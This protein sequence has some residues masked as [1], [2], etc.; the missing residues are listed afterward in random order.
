MICLYPYDMWKL[1]DE[2]IHSRHMKTQIGC[3]VFNSLFSPFLFGFW[4]LNS[5]VQVFMMVASPP[6]PFHLTLNCNTF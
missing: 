3:Y 1:E 6:E 5:G 4:W 2:R